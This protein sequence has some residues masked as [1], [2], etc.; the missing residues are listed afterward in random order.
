MRGHFGIE[1][2]GE[3]LDEL[4][5]LQKKVKLNLCKFDEWL[6]D[7]IGEYEKE[8]YN[9]GEAIAHY[10]GISEEFFITALI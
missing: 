7:E 10:Y 4:Y 1:N 5:L 8:G 9:M 2:P 6:H 3:Y